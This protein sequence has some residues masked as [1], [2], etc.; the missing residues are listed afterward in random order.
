M[1]PSAKGHAHENSAAKDSGSGN[2]SAT[3][4]DTAI[5]TATDPAAEGHS[6][7]SRIAKDPAAT[8]HSAKDPEAAPVGE[9]PAA[10]YP[11]TPGFTVKD[12]AD[13]VEEFA[14]LGLQEEY[15]NAG[16]N[17][18]D[19][20]SVVS[21]I[22]I[23]VDFTEEVLGEAIDRGCN[24]I[25]SH[26]PLLF[27]PLRQVVG[28]DHIQRIV[29]GALLA[30][31]S[32]YAAHTNLD[33]ATG[34]MSHYLGGKLGLSGM[35]LLSPEPEGSAT[36]VGV[37]GR[38]A[39]PMPAGDFLLKIKQA[40]GCGCIRHSALVKEKISTVAISTGAGRSYIGKA[41]D[42]GADLFISSDFRYNDFFVPD[43]RMIVADVGH[44][45]SEYCAIELLYDIITK[46][47]PTFAVHKSERSANPVN[48]LI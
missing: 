23:C 7:E 18:G 46:K 28:A 17:V 1:D 47:I 8:G 27:H 2:R 16:L 42:A 26:H 21:G 36:G 34:G 10:T 4:L 48:Y 6:P 9:C 15:D 35:R 5:S 30:G 19:Y 40:L 24:L 29:R 20:G 3:V 45:E 12:V 41:A 31:I 11:D 25:V 33:S 22:L 14:P 44:F 43:G 32:L 39:E 37:V 38:L 13:I